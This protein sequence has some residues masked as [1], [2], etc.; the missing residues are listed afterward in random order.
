MS[1]SY[2]GGSRAKA[3]FKA[4]SGRTI[5]AV[6]ASGSFNVS[7]AHFA[8]AAARGSFNVSGANVPATTAGGSFIVS[9]VPVDG[10]K[11]KSTFVVSGAHQ[12]EIFS[13]G[14]FTIPGFF[15]NV[16]NGTAEFLFDAVAYSSGD[17]SIVF[18]KATSSATGDIRFRLLPSGTPTDRD[19]ETKI[20][21][22]HL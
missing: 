13:S 17:T 15:R 22:F 14:S 8:G 12:T 19:W 16:I 20:Q 21:R 3:T 7:G 11:A 6:A 9:H 10:T 4:M 1:G 2:F 18:N 5:P